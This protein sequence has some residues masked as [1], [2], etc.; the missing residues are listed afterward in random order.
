[1]RRLGQAA[2]LGLVAGALWSWTAAAAVGDGIPDERPVAWI[3]GFM[4]AGTTY[5]AVRRLR[6]VDTWRLS[7][8]RLQIGETRV[9]SGRWHGHVSEAAALEVTLN[10]SNDSRHHRLSAVMAGGR[11]Q[12]MYDGSCYDGSVQALG[13][14]L[15]TRADIP[16][17]DHTR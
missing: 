2:A 17:T 10:E 16:F 1:V 13:S 5:M 14:W 6:F 8:G 9:R 4:A 3:M 15:A 7:P 12:T 11:H